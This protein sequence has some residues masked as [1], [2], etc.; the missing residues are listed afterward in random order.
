[1]GLGGPTIARDL[2]DGGQCRG[3]QTSHRG[4]YLGRQLGHLA[5]L[6]AGWGR[7]RRSHIQYFAAIE[8]PQTL[9]TRVPPEP[10]LRRQD[11]QGERSFEG[12]N[13]K[14]AARQRWSTSTLVALGH[15]RSILG[16]M[17]PRSKDASAHKAEAELTMTHEMPEACEPLHTVRVFL[18][19][20]SRRGNTDTEP[21][22]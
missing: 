15:Q 4:P 19:L 5:G 11:A 16:M 2:A 14:R 1:V 17:I 12:S 8:N 21:A 3:V 20:T 6:R 10:G 9:P 7:V 13:R 22:Q 18:T